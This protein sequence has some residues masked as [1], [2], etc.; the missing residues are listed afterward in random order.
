MSIKAYLS[1]D[2]RACDALFAEIEADF[3]KAKARF[4]DMARAYERHFEIEE[5]IFFPEF[6]AKT[7]ME[8]GPT[9][10]MRAEHAQ[11]RAL[12]EQMKNALASNDKKRFAAISETFLFLVQQHNGKEEAVLYAMGD[13]LFGAAADEMVERMKQTV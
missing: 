6:E 10:T 12:L 3:A 5:R 1:A 4:A 11:M 7:R 2:H 8:C 9:Q 13:R